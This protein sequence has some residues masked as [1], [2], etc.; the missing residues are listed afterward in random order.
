MIASTAPTP[1]TS[2]AFLQSCGGFCGIKSK[3]DMT[4]SNKLLLLVC[5]VD[6]KKS[7]VNA[8]KCCLEKAHAFLACVHTQGAVVMIVGAAAVASKWIPAFSNQDKTKETKGKCPKLKSA[9]KSSQSSGKRSKRKRKKVRFADEK[10]QALHQ[11]CKQLN[12]GPL[13]QFVS[14]V[15]HYS[16]YTQPVVLQ[17][18]D[19][20]LVVL[21]NLSIPIIASCVFGLQTS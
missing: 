12:T 10:G 20:S 15:P 5:F 3:H 1:F 7:T 4:R 2:V 21:Q 16:C 8:Q 11:V 14:R 17:T 6:M 13:D 19:S 9:L 18:A